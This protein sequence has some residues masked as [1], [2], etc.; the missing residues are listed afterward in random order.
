MMAKYIHEQPEWPKFEWDKAALADQ[1]AAVRHRQGRLIG[2][3]ES[4]GFSLR[5]EAVL[6]TLT[7]DVLTSSE[8]EGELLDPA[9]VRSS[10][11]RRLGM[12]IA[13]LVPA[14]RD[15]EGVVEMMLDATRKFDEPLTDDRLFTCF[16]SFWQ[17]KSPLSGPRRR[18]SR[19]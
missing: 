4:L 17:G 12:D 16:R 15:V 19:Q 9:Q 1:L 3:M 13:G 5:E 2:R 14:D 7:R 10:I 18:A 8:I 11:A 6:Q